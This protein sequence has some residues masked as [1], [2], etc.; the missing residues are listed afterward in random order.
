LSTSSSQLRSYAVVTASY[1]GFTLTDGALRML[2][3]LHFHTL[4]YSPFQLAALFLLYELFGVV[5]NLLGGWIG[6]RTGLK[7]TLFS[8]L[9]LQIVALV[10]LSALSTQWHQA[11]QVA[12]VV[13]AQG[14]AGIAKDL[15]KLSA[16]SS[17]KLLIPN[18]ATGRL[19]KWVALL[20]GSKNTLKGVGF[21]LGGLLLAGLGFRVALWAMA[22]ALLA[23]ALITA[24]LLPGDLG[25]AKAKVQFSRIFAKSRVINLL[26]AARMCLFG[27]R[28]VWFVVALPVFLY[29]VVGWSFTQVGTYMA[30][31]VIGY[32]G[33]QAL[34]PRILE[35]R[36]QGERDH[37]RSAQRWAFLLAAIPVGIVVA[38]IANLP[39]T[40]TIVGG[41]A[42]FGVA[43]AVNSALHSYLILA[44]AD[45]DAVAL[46]VGFY[47]M[48]NAAGRLLGTLLSGLVY[49]FAG[50]VGCL[51]VAAL[52]VAAAGVF[53]L[54]F[55]DTR[56]RAQAA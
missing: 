29:D 50:L 40:L 25:R 42:A 1:W 48:A 3:L 39:P 34:T 49:Q 26:S 8:G 41:L 7:V 36:A 20:T 16:K 37:A 18:E 52:L 31:W 54:A 27:A 55:P 2:V 21:F 28:D 30:A 15:T 51:L 38:L 32:G 10:S 47:Y 24:L 4:G 6:S 14:L 5:T 17:I 45:E 33:V 56:A 23:T 44:Y 46:D 19:F 35:R 9:G 13:A 22:I 12:Y 43:F 11:V 53:A